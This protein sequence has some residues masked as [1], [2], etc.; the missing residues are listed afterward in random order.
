MK[1]FIAF[2]ILAG[3]L[4]APAYADWD[5]ALEAREAA[6]RKAGQQR[7][8]RQKA[9]H[10]KMIRDAS[11]KAYRDALGKEAVG[12]SDAEVVRMYKQREADAVKQAAIGSKSG[13]ATSAQSPKLDAN[14]RVQHDAQMKSM[15]GKSVSDLEKMND[16]EL[17]A[18]A[19]AMEKKYGK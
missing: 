7:A 8:A 10:D 3:L 19:S 15:T 5:P 12:K 16:K 9:E 17:E 4:A 1:K 2:I 14:T 6:E 11:A 18:F 13:Y